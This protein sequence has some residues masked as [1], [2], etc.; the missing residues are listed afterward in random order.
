MASEI[1]RLGAEQYVILTTFRK[2]GT[3]VPTP[4]W[5]ASQN[6][7]LVVWSERNA[8]KVKRIRRDGRVE[9][10]GCD[11]RGNKT[12]GA[13]VTG[14]ARIL[15]G[16]ASERV[17]RAIARKYGIVGQVTMFLSKLRGGK[18]RTI[19]IAIRLDV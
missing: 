16:E 8:G 9:V 11:F 3:P 7:E 14:Q 2:D 19:G 5:V 12:H 6:G 17:R 18:Q 15:D 10:Q 1:E 4:L 13:K